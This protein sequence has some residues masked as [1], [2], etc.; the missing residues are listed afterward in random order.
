MYRQAAIEA[1][2]MRESD[3]S[4]CFCE[5][6]QLDENVGVKWYNSQTTAIKTRLFQMI[7]YF[8]GIGPEVKSDIF[9]HTLAD[10]RTKFGYLTEIITVHCEIDNKRLRVDDYIQNAQEFFDDNFGIVLADLHP[11][12]FGWNKNG[13]AILDFDNCWACSCGKDSLTND[14]NDIKHAIGIIHSM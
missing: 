12:N 3:S 9:E 1:L 10:G 14:E 6:Y 2:E 7:A 5:F 8:A 4:G 11:K 13:F